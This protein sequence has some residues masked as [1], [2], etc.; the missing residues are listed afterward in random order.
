MKR[1]K[2]IFKWIYL[3]WLAVLIALVAAALLYVDNLLK[4]YEAAQPERQVREVVTQLVADASDGDFWSKY[5][6]A[7]PQPGGFE[8]GMDVGKTYLELY[9]GEN[10]DF[11]QK[12]A[13]A[14]DELCYIVRNGGTELAEIRLKAAGPAQ[15][16]LAVFTMRDWEL[17]SVKPLLEKK[18][19][20]LTVPTDFTVKVN[21][22]LLSE[23]DGTVNGSEIAYTVS[24]IY[25]EPEFE[26]AD[27]EGELAAY[28]VKN[29]KVMAEYYD[30]AL[31]LPAALTVKVDGEVREGV[32]TDRD[33]VV[34]YDIAQLTKPQVEIC[35]HYGNVFAY[36]GGNKLPLTYAV[37]EVNERYRVQVSGTD[38]PAETAVFSENSEYA[39]IADYVDGLPGIAS[40]QIAVLEE[41]ASITVTDELGRPVPVEADGGEIDLTGWLG[42]ADEVPAKVSDE[43]DVLEVAQKWSLMMSNDLKFAELSD[44]LL[45]GSYQYEVAR[46][47]A[48]GI[49]ITFT[50]SHVLLNPT[51]TEN[52]V[53]NFTWLTEDCFSVDISFVKHMK[54][55][56]TGELVDDPMNDRFYFVRHEG[57]WK[58]A[59]L[60]EILNDAGA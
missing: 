59:S 9:Q 2:G 43:I 21:G 4:D 18:E 29:G 56:R 11:A 3:V 30:Y 31:T 48:T 54:L 58:L 44:H 13:G 41:N 33:R 7:Q 10:V 1:Q 38:A 50:S 23:A 12:N 28:M 37:V 19:Y 35:D 8:A 46:K 42:G 53:T 22:Q 32:P 47:Y 40:Y 14:E 15:T 5:G 20:S 60:K 49:D 39:Q 51:F 6:L 52:S 16:K 34:H 45:R 36:N 26:I 25:L 55:T 57:G 17:T 27:A 24:G